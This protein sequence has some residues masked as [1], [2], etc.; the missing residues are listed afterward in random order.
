M[1]DGD[2]RQGL[3]PNSGRDGRSQACRDADSAAYC[4]GSSS[5]SRLTKASRYSH[6]VRTAGGEHTFHTR[7]PGELIIQ[8]TH[9]ER[10]SRIGPPRLLL[11]CPGL[12]TGAR[13]IANQKPIGFSCLSAHPDVTFSRGAATIAHSNDLVSDHFLLKSTRFQARSG[14]KCIAL[15]IKSLA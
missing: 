13:L 9:K 6:L 2:R 4:V 7:I 12:T 3:W 1:N 8:T 15:R 14:R 11:D 10:H 5:R